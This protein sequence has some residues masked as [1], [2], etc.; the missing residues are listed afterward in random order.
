MHGTNSMAGIS[1]LASAFILSHYCRRFTE[2]IKL[3]WQALSAGVAVAYKFINI[4]P[5][6]NAPA[7]GRRVSDLEPCSMR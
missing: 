1:L 7:N 2:N 3:R 5:E 4:I 6:L